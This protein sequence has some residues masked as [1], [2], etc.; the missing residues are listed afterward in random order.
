MDHN[1]IPLIII[2][3]IVILI[4][5]IANDAFPGRESPESFASV[6]DF[7]KAIESKTSEAIQNVA[8]VYND[9]NMAVTNLNVTSRLTSPNANIDNIISGR[10]R[11][12]S[13][14]ATNASVGTLNAKTITGTGI[15]KVVG[16]LTKNMTV[17]KLNVGNHL[18]AKSVGAGIVT[19]KVQV[20]TVH[21]GHWGSWSGYMYCPANHYVCGARARVEKKQGSG[22]DTAM[23]GMQL[24]CC[25]FAD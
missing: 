7:K 16:D 19:G 6:P 21:P 1:L 10:V 18:S 12:P 24:L 5:L 11:T 8:S 15:N 22:D 20:K 2:G 13:L 23:N 9:D 4:L 14:T 17:D 3:S 25:S